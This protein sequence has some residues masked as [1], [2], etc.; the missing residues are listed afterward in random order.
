MKKTVT[1]YGAGYV[2]LVTGACLAELGH[3]VMLIDTNQA[4]I[5]DLSNGVCP[6][7]EVDLEELLNRH[8]H[9][10]RIKFSTDLAMGV[11]HGLFQFIAV[12][13]P[14]AEDG[15]A[16]LQH[17]FEVVDGIAQR[18]SEYRLIVTKSTVPVGTATAVQRRIQDSLEQRGVAIEFDVMANPEFLK[19]GVA[20]E[21]FMQP[22]RIIIGVDNERALKHTRELYADLDDNGQRFIIMNVASA[23]LTK[24]AA[25]AY[26]AA[27]ISFMNE[28]SQLAERLG[29]DIDMIRRGIG[30][31]RRI[32]QH[33]LF[34][35]CGFGGSC[36]PKDVRALQKMAHAVDY[37]ARLIDAIDQVNEQQKRMLFEKI[38][39]YFSG[40]LAGKIIAL[41][42]LA[43]KPHTDDMREA[44]SCVLIKHLLH[45]GAHVHAYDPAASQH[46]HRLFGEHSQ[47]TLCDEMTTVLDNADVLAIVTEWDE[48]KHPDFS[49]IRDKLRYPAIFDGRNIY[50]PNTVREYSLNYYAIGHG[51]T[52]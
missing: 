5:T 41:W 49:L 32:G 25:N 35:G 18:L 8:L 17:V 42:G 44:P 21:D 40:D 16:D 19:Q 6:I 9:T 7:Y 34:A 43:F 14:S 1:I 20:I 10:G 11:Q 12:G 51:D 39:R 48:F 37:D 26:L 4:K 24:Y 13:T 28:M 23:E 30:S 22:D 52:I 38:M 27:R 31:D 46:A 47:F 3:D 15:S 50:D 29:A 45:A 33:F 36:F 2:G